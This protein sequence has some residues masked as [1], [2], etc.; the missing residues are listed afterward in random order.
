MAKTWAHDLKDKKT[1][2]CTVFHHQFT[3]AR[4]WAEAVLKEQRDKAPKVENLA[5]KM[6]PISEVPFSTTNRAK[7]EG[8]V[9]GTKMDGI[10]V[11]NGNLGSDNVDPNDY[12][13]F[14]LAEGV[15]QHGHPTGKGAQ[16]LTRVVEH[17]LASG[18]EDLLLGE[19]I[20]YA[21]RHSITVPLA[22][23]LTAGASAEDQAA[24]NRHLTTISD[25]HIR[26]IG[27]RPK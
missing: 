7:V 8:P 20:G 21:Q 14:H 11:E 23:R 12:Y 16:L 1:R 22:D 27:H 19:V 3:K 4:D 5:G 2:E 17:V 26:R 18:N 24:L 10:T 13:V 6:V 9:I 15:H 25:F